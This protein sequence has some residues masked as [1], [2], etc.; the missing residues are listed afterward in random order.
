MAANRR[1]STTGYNAYGG[2]AYSPAYDGNAVRAPR[3]EEELR[4]APKPKQRQPVQRY[5]R[6]QARVRQ[7]G[8]VAPFAVVGFLAV[9]IFAA[10]LIT[11]YVQLTVANDEMVSLRK[12]L[13][14]L[15]SR[16]STLSAEYEKVFDL[17]TIQEAVGDSMVRPT[18]DQVVYIDLSAPDTVTLYQEEGLNAGF[19][20]LWDGIRD[21]FDGIIEY[22]R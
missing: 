21:M 3:R 5:E 11:S 19:R 22:F 10:M 12:E 13:S 16:N 15:Q 7:A 9:V 4:R 2:A 8:Q 20:G 14:N 6:I 1:R 18:S 17:A